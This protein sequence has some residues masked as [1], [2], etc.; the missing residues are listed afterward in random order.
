MNLNGP[1]TIAYRKRKLDLESVEKNVFFFLSFVSGFFQRAPSDVE[2]GT[3]T[4][5]VT[6]AEPYEESTS[7]S[8]LGN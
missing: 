8:D 3:R 1:N 6:F 4:F 2:E 5:N 7:K